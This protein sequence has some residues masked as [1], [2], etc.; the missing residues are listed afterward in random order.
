MSWL[1]NQSIFAALRRAA[2][3]AGVI[4][5]ENADNIVRRPSPLPTV[6]PLTLSARQD[7]VTEPEASAMFCYD[8]QQGMSLN[9][10]LALLLVDAKLSL[11]SSAPSSRATSSPSATPAEARST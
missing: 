8:C 7:F 6:M 9:V 10:G 5:T 4:Y 11:T 3:R 1:K 2:V